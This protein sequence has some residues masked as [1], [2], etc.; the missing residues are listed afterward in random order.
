MPSSGG[1][2]EVEADHDVLFS[3]KASGRHANDGEV[4]AALRERL[5]AG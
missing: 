1:V 5:E 3:K 4:L 2:F